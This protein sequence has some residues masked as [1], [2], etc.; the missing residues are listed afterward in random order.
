LFCTFSNAV[1]R[2]TSTLR[3]SE[4]VTADSAS[5]SSVTWAILAQYPEADYFDP[6]VGETIDFDGNWVTDNHVLLH[7]TG[8]YESETITLPTVVTVARNSEVDETVT[9]N[10]L[11][12]NEGNTGLATYEADDV[13]TGEE[14]DITVVLNPALA[15]QDTAYMY[16]IY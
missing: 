3:S 5:G 16:T 9:D 2:G 13:P 4:L 8:T 12:L 6:G 10:P 7:I 15:Q 1:P 11:I 14:Y